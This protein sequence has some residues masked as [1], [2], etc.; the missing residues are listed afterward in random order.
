MFFLGAVM[1]LAGLVPSI[2]VLRSGWSAASAV[3][4]LSVFA[5]VGA[6]LIAVARS[7]ASQAWKQGR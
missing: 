5:P 2:V 6:I 7:K 1:L 4:W 3:S